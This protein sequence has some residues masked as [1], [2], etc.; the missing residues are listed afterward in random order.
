MPEATRARYV[1]LTLTL[2]L[3]AIV[4]L[5][6]VCISTASLVIKGELALS[7]S[8]V[9]YIF[10]IY[11]I[12]YALFEVPGGWLVDRYGARW[13]L[14]RIVVAWSLMTAATGLAWSFSSLFVIRM[15]FGMGEAGAYPSMAWV[16]ARWLPARDRGRAFGLT[17]MAGL[18]GASLTQ[19][20]VVAL[21]GRMTWRH[22]FPLFG[23]V[24]LVWAVAWVSWFRDN[25]ASHRR[26]NEAE[27]RIIG[28]QSS[29]AGHAL[30]FPG[31]DYGTTAASAH[32]ASCTAGRSMVGIST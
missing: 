32:F 30:G 25:P 10:S 4:Y 24:G 1:V 9:G 5:D 15:L 6:R 8:Q 19:P 17:V 11:T 3:S 21:L 31:S 28:A 12:A 23:A 18:L 16:Y 2:L 13:M 20:L 26:V 7:D 27:L 29:D 22:I 14:T